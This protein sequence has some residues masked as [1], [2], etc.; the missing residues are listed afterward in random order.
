[1]GTIVDEISPEELAGQHTFTYTGACNGAMVFLLDFQTLYTKYPNAFVRI[2][3]MKCDGNAIKFDANNFFYGDIEEM[4]ITV[5][6]CSIFGV[7]ARPMEM[8]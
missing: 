2:D 4:A 1:M 7:K 5:L 6:K 8:W 3:E